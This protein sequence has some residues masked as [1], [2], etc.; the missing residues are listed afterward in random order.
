MSIRVMTIVWDHYPGG[1]T[2]LLSMLALADW[3]DDDGRCFPSIASIAR[4]IRLKERQTQRLVNKLIDDGYVRVIGNQ[5]GGKPGESRRYQ[6][7]ISMLTGVS[8]DTPIIGDTGVI[9]DADG[10][11]PRRETGVS[12]DTLTVIE[13]SLT[14]KSISPKKKINFVTW[15]KHVKESGEKLISGYEPV[16]KYSKQVGLPGDWIY[17]AWLKFSD[18]YSTDPQYTSKLYSDW[19]RVFLNAIEGNWFGLWASRDGQFVLTTAGI[20]A[21]LATREVSQ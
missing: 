1:G 11:H 19:R 20:Q 18:R 12:H 7:V 13:P 8:H 2:D 14:V 9:Q 5:F 10:C 17:I 16:W 6:I 21:D 4:K 3:S 15:E